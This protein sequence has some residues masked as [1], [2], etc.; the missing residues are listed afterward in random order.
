M[1]LFFI[2]CAQMFETIFLTGESFL[3]LID[4]ESNE[5]KKQVGEKGLFFFSR[6]TVIF[7]KQ[8]VEK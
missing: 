6:R 5:I 4:S 8:M 3:D 7:M 2:R 1:V